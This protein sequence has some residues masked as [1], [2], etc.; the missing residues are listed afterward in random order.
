MDLLRDPPGQ[1]F[2]RYLAPS[3]SASLVTSIYILA[4]T[5]MIGR[6]VGAEALAA[7]NL[8]LPLFAL[9]F[10]CG[11][12]FG[13]G[14][15]V[16]YSVA[17][18]AGDEAYAQTVWTTALYCVSVTAVC[19]TVICVVFLTPICHL[20]GADES[21]LGMV[22]EYAIF[23][24]G[25]TPF[26]IFSTFLQAFVR[27]DRDPKRSMAAVLTGSAVNIVFDYIFIFPLRM[28]LTGGAAATVMG[29]AVT[30]LILLT[31]W[32]TEQNGLH[33][34][35]RQVSREA[36]RK[37]V[38]AGAP[39]FL[40]EAA[41]A[42]TTFSFNRQLL[43]YLGHQGVVVYGVIANYAIVL[44]SL[45]NG[46]GQA[47]QPIMAANFGA[48]AV[49]RVR[50]VQRLGLITVLVIGLAAVATAYGMPD[51]LVALFVEPDAAL[52][53]MARPAIRLYAP[54]FVPY[55]VNLFLAVYFQS[56]V[57]AVPSMAIMLL[58]GV[59]LPLAFVMLL[60]ALWG[61]AAIFA[62]VLLAECVTAVVALFFL[63]RYRLGRN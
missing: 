4:D 46:T 17:R 30:V 57:R 50:V 37:I 29:N 11:M 41:T 20:L 61:G 39:S 53:R 35:R 52:L 10:A 18:G 49:A 42:L 56:V 15:G 12:L 63:A 55:G 14:G 28:G 16:L 31:H 22:Q 9:L 32:R 44:Q 38:A 34:R 54:A 51:T 27:N 33:F 43:R 19:A 36:A 47:A 13:A 6:G 8:V 1:L 58:R 60:P 21:N 40:I 25:G 23:V 5:M 59:A 26:F 24:S 7:L 45:F 62:A 2:R 48:G 3:V